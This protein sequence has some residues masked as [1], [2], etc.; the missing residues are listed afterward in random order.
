M[1]AP[2]IGAHRLVGDGRSLAL[3]TQDGEVDWWCAPELDDP[4]LLWSLLDPEGAAARW[5]DARPVAAEGR[6][7]GPVVET[8]LMVGGRR[9]RC[10]DGLVRLDG[11]SHLL[12]LV[13]VER[14]EDG[15]APLR[16]ELS[17]AASTGRGPPPENSSLR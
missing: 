12:R 14:S 4:P 8:V 13:R 16:H 6:P 7:A 15:P 3:V 11:T 17:L 5:L 2:P 10:R 1:N 9:I